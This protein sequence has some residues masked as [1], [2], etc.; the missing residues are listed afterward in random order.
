MVTFVTEG[1]IISIVISL[2]RYIVHMMETGRLELHL[3]S[4]KFVVKLANLWLFGSL[5]GFVMGKLNVCSS[6]AKHVHHVYS[7]PVIS[8]YVSIPHKYSYG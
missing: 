6:G 1:F 4:K 8:L 7:H 5:L 2:P 3:S